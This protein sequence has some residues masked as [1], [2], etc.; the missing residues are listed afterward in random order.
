MTPLMAA[1]AGAGAT[2]AIGHSINGTAYR[3]FAYPLHQV[4]A[5]SM[6]SLAAMGIEVDGLLTTEDGE[7][8]VG[9]ASRRKVEIELERITAK[10][11]RIKVIARN[12]G[13][14]YDGST[15]AEIVVQTEKALAAM[16]VMNSAAGGSQRRR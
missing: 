12:G 15:A 6:E 14:L 9:S 11:T 3:T 2:S 8:I 16:K 1:L 13:L 5:A 7:A 4:K 10:A